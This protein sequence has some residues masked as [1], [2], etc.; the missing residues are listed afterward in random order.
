LPARPRI[1][2]SREARAD[3]RQARAYYDGQR[4]GLGRE[5]VVAIVD[6]LEVVVE[7]PGSFPQ[8]HSDVRRAIVKRFPYGVFFRL[9][10]GAVRVIAIMHLHRDPGTWRRRG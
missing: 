6:T 1:G 10:G 9:V 4:N 3:L 2:L 8:V 7:R 5:F